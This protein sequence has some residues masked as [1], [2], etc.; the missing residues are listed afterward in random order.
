VLEPFLMRSVTHYSHTVDYVVRMIVWRQLARGDLDVAR[1][2]PVLLALIARHGRLGN[3]G[4][5]C[6]ATY[7]ALR[8]EITVPFDAA[9]AAVLNCGA[10]STVAVLS[11]AAAGLLDHRIFDAAW[12]VVIGEDGNGPFWPLLLE[13]KVRQWPRHGQ[14]PVANDLITDLIAMSVSIF[15]EGRLP[16]VFDDVEVDDYAEVERAIERRSSQYDDDD[17]EEAEDQ[18]VDDFWDIPI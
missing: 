2:T 1:W 17:D 16:P 12:P 3:D 5:V 13:W 8:L 18:E 10:L 14:I 11:T 4:E 9:E 7:A 15:D 6:W